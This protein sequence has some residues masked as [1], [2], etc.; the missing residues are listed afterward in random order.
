MRNLEG[1]LRASARYAIPIVAA[2][3]T[4]AGCSGHQP[5]DGPMVETP[6]LEVEFLDEH[7]LPAGTEAFGTCLGGLSALAYDTAGGD[8]LALSDSRIDPRY[9]TLNIEL[10]ERSIERVEVLSVGRFLTREETPFPDRRI[11]PEGL[12]L[13]GDG[14]LW[15]SSEGVAKLAVPPFVDRFHLDGGHWLASAPIPL[16]YRPPWN[17]GPPRGVR[18]N[19]GFESLTLSPDGTL[20]TAASEASLRQDP[21]PHRAGDQ[22]SARILVWNVESVARLTG[23]YR[24]PLVQAHDD[25]EAGGLVELLALEND[26]FLALERSWGPE[27]GFTVALLEAFMPTPSGAPEGESTA[28]GAFLTK[29]PLID[30]GNA[31]LRLLN[32][33]GLA[34]GPRL[35]DGRR[36]LLVLGDN[37]ETDCPAPADADPTGLLLFA[38][39][40]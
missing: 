40:E 26:R 25:V 27:S 16:E 20:L 31:G 38:L 24:Y 1:L 19:Q 35:A 4:L 30:F 34:L 13:A 39:D 17:G 18:D 11:D 2:G 23:A 14:S 12:A 37:N 15:L 36:S 8:Y 21:A 22:S 5:P 9:Y 3:L 10:G 29:R 32:W 28:P 33:E 7:Y 6:S